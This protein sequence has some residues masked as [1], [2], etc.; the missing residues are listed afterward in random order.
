VQCQAG[1]ALFPCIGAGIMQSLDG[2]RGALYNAGMYRLAKRSVMH[3]W[4]ACVAILFGALAP[5]LSHSFSPPSQAFAGAEICTSTGLK[6][7][8]PAIGGPAKLFLDTALDKPKHCGD[9]VLHALALGL[10]PS[11]ALFAMLEPHAL[12]PFL[13]YQAH[14]PLFPWT[15]AS[16]RAPP[17]A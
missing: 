9:C 10:L 5:A 7:V 15:V 17:L 13:F 3:A 11:G 16:S 2:F 4:I 12:F 8:A 6:F 1:G 14:S